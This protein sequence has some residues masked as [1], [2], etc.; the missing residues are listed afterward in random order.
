MFPKAGHTKISK[1]SVTVQRGDRCLTEF[2]AYDILKVL[3]QAKYLL[4][5]EIL[6]HQFIIQG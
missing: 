3:G 5:S 2:T 6:T 1:A 4:D